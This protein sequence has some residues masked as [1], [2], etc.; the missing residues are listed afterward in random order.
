MVIVLRYMLPD[1]TVTERFFQFVE[2][3]DKTA[4]GL[5]NTIKELLKPLNLEGKLIAQTY[6]GAAV[7]S[8]NVRGVQMLMRQTYPHAVFVHCYAHQA[9][10]ILQTLCSA[11]MKVLK[12][13]FADLSS[14][15]TFFSGSPKRTSALADAT[16]KRIPR[17][18]ATRW[19]F[20][21][22]TVNAVWENREA[23]LKCMDNIRTQPGWDEKTISEAGGLQRKLCDRDFLR[24][25]DFFSLLMPEVSSS[26]YFTPDKVWYC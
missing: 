21:S 1:N 19:N 9:N 14:F 2:V 10:L 5:S 26:Y 23:L 11:H 4:L 18:P 22:R 24:I 20:K 16:N 7:M 25:L 8:G 13:F 17:P 12:V 15:A 6:D 3:K